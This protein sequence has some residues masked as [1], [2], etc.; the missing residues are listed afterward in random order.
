MEELKYYQNMAVAL[1]EENRPRNKFYDS[2]DVAIDGGGPL[3]EAIRKLPWMVHFRST[4][5]HDAY[6]AARRSLI[7]SKMNVNVL[8]P[9]GDPDTAKNAE[10]MEKLLEYN[11]WLANRRGPRGPFI[12][13]VSDA[14]KFMAVAY[15]VVDVNEEY[16]GQTGPRVDAI[17]QAGRF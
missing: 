4:S 8:A 16:R 17:K 6:A 7:S 5:L 2:V 13:I 3:P 15:Q 12:K 9:S 1:L 10:K 11:F 14:L